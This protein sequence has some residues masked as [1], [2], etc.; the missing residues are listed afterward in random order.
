MT[1]ED[2]MIKKGKDKYEASIGELGGAKEYYNCGAEGGMA[3]ATCLKALK[4]KNVDEADWAK[5]WET[6]MKG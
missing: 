1:A 4:V 2:D 5:R 6:A 3:V